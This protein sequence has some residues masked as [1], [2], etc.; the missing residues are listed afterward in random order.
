MTGRR[1]VS[2]RVLVLVLLVTLTS[3]ATVPTSSPVRVLGRAGEGERT[4]AAGPVDGSNPLDLVRDF[5]FASGSSIDRHGAARRFLVPEAEGW[6]DT[7]GLTVLDGQFDTV[8]TPGAPNASDATTIRI[9]GTAIGRLGSAGAFEPDQTIFQQDV[10]VVRREGQWRIASLPSGVVLPLSIFLDNYRPVRTWFI[11]PVRRLAAADQRYLPAVPAPAQAARVVELLLDGPSAALAGA[12]VSALPPGARLRSNVATGP[13]GALVVDLTQ[14]GELDEPTR[15]LIAGQVVLTLD[16]VNVPRVRLLV[17][18]EPLLPDRPDVTR[19]DVAD[20]VAEAQPGPDVPGLVAADGRLRQISGADP[21]VVLPGPAGNGTYDIESAATSVDGRQLAAVVRQADRRALPVGG[22]ADPVLTPVPLDAATMTRPTWAPA[23]N[24]VWTVLD[25]RT[26]ARVLLDGVGSP[27]TGEVDAEDL[28]AIG[29]IR[30]LRLSR[31]GMRV[32][33]VIGG[34][35]YVGA[36]ARSADG[37]VRI[38]NVRRLRPLDLGEVVAGDWRTG[39]AV[40][41]VSRG[42]DP[43]IAQTTVDG[44]GMQP[45]LG[46][47]L[48]P[49]LSAI[50][51]ASNRPLLVTDQTG[52]WSFAFGDQAAWRQVLGGA[53]DA[54]PLYPG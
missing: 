35:L 19:A 24:E 43:L 39:D 12:A 46:I 42:A 47:N 26:V 27:R 10:T 45:V 13:D 18:G 7:A 54:V 11:D 33:A 22:I 6:D 9:R 32:L 1:G 3:C 20:L 53:P 36:V 8:P 40:V 37:Q 44:L 15:R 23:G 38:R 28:A 25:G 34:G 50:A 48:T 17:D 30:D 4:A 16:E 21:T 41:T 2:V 49:P 31:D 29:P 51:A 5:V 14:V 52:V